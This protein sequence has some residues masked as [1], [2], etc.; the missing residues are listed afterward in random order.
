[1]GVEKIPFQLKRYLSGQNCV[2]RILRQAS[3]VSR[4]VASCVFISEADR[5]C[6]LFEK[7]KTRKQ[8]Y[9][10]VPSA[11]SGKCGTDRDIAI[12]RDGK[13]EVFQGTAGTDNG[14]P[15]IV[16]SLSFPWKL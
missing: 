13:F 15:K 11:A 5:L 9:E 8:R 1:V 6:I 2:F 7:E 16:G 3:S 4:S 14:L 10:L 12:S